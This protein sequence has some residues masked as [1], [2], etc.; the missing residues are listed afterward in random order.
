MSEHIQ[1]SA[2]RNSAAYQ[3]GEQANLDGY[4]RESNPYTRAPSR[5]FWF[6]GFDD[7]QI[8]RDEWEAANHERAR[9]YA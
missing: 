2:S 8:T 9:H 3:Q 7:A 5:A 6:K 4:L 1:Q